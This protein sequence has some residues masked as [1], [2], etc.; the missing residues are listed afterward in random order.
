MQNRAREV[1]EEGA[2][3]DDEL[4]MNAALDEGDAADIRLAVE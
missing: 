3:T 4:D 2:A 1:G